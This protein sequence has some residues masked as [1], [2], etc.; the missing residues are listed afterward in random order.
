MVDVILQQQVETS[1]VFGMCIDSTSELDVFTC[2]LGPLFRNRCS[3]RRSPLRNSPLSVNSMM[4]DGG[5]RCRR[6]GN[7]YYREKYKHRIAVVEVATA[8]FGFAVCM[9]RCSVD[10]TDLGVNCWPDD[11][12]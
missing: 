3:S 4:I 9:E 10:G 11:E 5:N 8:V 1:K 12:C 6:S 2:S 7:K